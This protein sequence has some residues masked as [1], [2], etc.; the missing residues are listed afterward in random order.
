MFS[1]PALLLL[2]TLLPPPGASCYVF[3][4]NASAFT[5]FSYYTQKATSLG[6][7]DGSARAGDRRSNNASGLKRGVVD[8]SKS[9]AIEA[10]SE[11]DG[12]ADDS[13]LVCY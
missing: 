6:D 11:V 7:I 12:I 1:L 5:H 4:A 10:V 3:L 8:V 13:E 2:A 9:L